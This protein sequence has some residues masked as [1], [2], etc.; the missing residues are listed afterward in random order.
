MSTKSP[1][2]SGA[3]GTTKAAVPAR[4]WL[5]AEVGGHTRDLSERWRTPGTGRHGGCT[6]WIGV[7]EREEGAAAVADVVAAARRGLQQEVSGR[8]A[9]ALPNALR[10]SA[11]NSSNEDAHLI[12]EVAPR[13]SRRARCA[14]RASMAAAVWRLE[15]AGATQIV[16]PHQL[17]GQR[18]ANALLRPG[19]VE[20][21]DPSDPGTGGE[22]DLEEIVL[23]ESCPADG[24]TLRQLRDRDLQV[25]IVAIKRGDEPI[26]LRPG[27]E[28]VDLAWLVEVAQPEC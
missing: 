22:V 13:R 19:L 1:I 25:A 5:S 27:P 20:F 3:G 24:V 4:A 6:P 17:A 9:F 21:L 16:S 8:H 18:I 26:R 2:R 28:D 15:L 12:R 7:A 23:C 11:R 14:R 10:E